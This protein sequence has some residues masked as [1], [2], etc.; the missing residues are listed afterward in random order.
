MHSNVTDRNIEEAEGTSRERPAAEAVR[1][2]NLQRDAK[3]ELGAAV[4]YVARRYPK[5]AGLKDHVRR[6]AIALENL[7]TEERDLMTAFTQR[8]GQQPDDG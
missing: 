8:A 1:L 7:W 3:R 4:D 5:A 6:L 2:L